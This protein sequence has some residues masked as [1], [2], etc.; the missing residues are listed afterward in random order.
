LTD[1]KTAEFV[2]H[3]NVERYERLLKTDL[4]EP[5]RQYI[6]RRLGEER[7]FLACIAADGQPMAA[8]FFGARSQFVKGAVIAFLAVELLGP[9][10]GL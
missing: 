6:T 7:E 2:S 5:E 10:L 1:I 3:Q 4:S 9:T 8:T